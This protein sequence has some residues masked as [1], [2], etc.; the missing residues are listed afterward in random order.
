MIKLNKIIS[1]LM[2]GVLS[3]CATAPLATKQMDLEAKAFSPPQGKANVYVLRSAVA[4]SAIAFQVT[5]DGVRM[6]TMTSGRYLMKSVEPGTHTAEVF[7][8]ESADATQFQAVAGEVYFFVTEPKMGWASARAA[9]KQVDTEKG[10]AKVR[11]LTRSLS[12]Q[13]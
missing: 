11:G 2:L 13:Y 8:N 9:L 6:G 10:K 4:G 5:L 7:T 3:S 1:V 12:I